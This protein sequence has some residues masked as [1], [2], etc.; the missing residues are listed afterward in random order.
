MPMNL[1]V[2]AASID[3]TPQVPVPLSGFAERKGLYTQVRDNLEINLLALK[4]GE[5]IILIY[6]VDTLFVPEEFVNTVVEQFGTQY[7]I[8]EQDIWMVASHT[9]YAP[10]LDREKPALGKIDE[11]YYEM[12]TGKLL[13]L[14]RQVLKGEYKN[15]VIEYGND[16]SKL[17]V[18]RR[19]KLI[20]PKGKFGLYRKVLMYPDY[21]G[22]K[23]D[24][25]HL[26]KLVGEDGKLLSVIWNYACH[27]VGY[28]HLHRVTS[29]FVGAVRQHLRDEVGNKELP[30]GFLIGFAGNLKPDLTAVT[31]N[32]WKEKAAYMFQ[33]G[34]KNLRFIDTASYEAWV[35][36]LW[37]EVKSVLHE[38]R[39]CTK[40]EL[41][42]AQYTLPLG[43][44]IGDSSHKIYLKK[45]QLAKGVQM[46]GFSAEVLAEYKTIVADVM[47]S[48]NLLTVGCLAGTRIYL[49]TDRNV[50]E[51]GY[52]VHGFQHKFGVS[53][54]FKN[55][56]VDKVRTAVSKL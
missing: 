24:G 7:N 53:G 40:A 56:L 42:S 47:N 33:L 12:V 27:P 29:E 9:H 44:I 46:L 8:A 25:I 38:V 20:R 23:D 45:L 10:S 52:E 5:K 13:Q 55:G 18:N 16:K 17:N 50:A 2:S 39:P 51:G 15:A 37:Q 3:I 35:Q 11:A 34:P 26:I 14:T 31:N 30:V 1:R 43:D 41:I 49:P 32:R 4:Q 28:P 36:M 6:S 54:N 48:E 19:K 21:E 22:V